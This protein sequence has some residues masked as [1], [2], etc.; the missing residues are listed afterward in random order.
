[1]S[2]QLPFPMLI[3]AL[4][5]LKAMPQGQ[6]N[7]W[8]QIMQFY[9]LEQDNSSCE[10]IPEAARGILGKSNTKVANFVHQWLAKQID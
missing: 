9:L 2:S 10:H 3:H 7:A 4:Q 5:A 1:L 6:Q 8:Q